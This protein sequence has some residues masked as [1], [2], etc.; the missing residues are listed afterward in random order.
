[1]RTRQRTGVAHF[2]DAK[3]QRQTKACKRAFTFLTPAKLNQ[4]NFPVFLKVKMR[5]RTD[6][7]DKDKLTQ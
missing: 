6:Q 4:K 3:A 1:M 5:N 2:Q 7:H